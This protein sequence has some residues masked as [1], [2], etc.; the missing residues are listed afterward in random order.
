MTKINS[1]ITSDGMDMEDNY[2]KIFSDKLYELS[3]NIAKSRNSRHPIDIEMEDVR[4][5]GE[6]LINSMNNNKPSW[7]L[8]YLKVKT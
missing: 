4:Q 3:K 8:F 7:D 1:T 6:I 2:Q 5:A